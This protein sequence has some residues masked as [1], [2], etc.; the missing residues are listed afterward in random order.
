MCSM[1]NTPEYNTHK[2]SK[3]ECYAKVRSEL[4]RAKTKSV[5][6]H[7]MSRGLDTSTPPPLLPATYT[8][9]LGWFCP[10][11]Q[12]SLAVLISP[13]GNKTTTTIFESN[14]KQSLIRCWPGG[15]TLTRFIPRFPAIGDES[16]LAEA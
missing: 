16:H 8:S 6:S 9:L 15:W 7:L 14:M 2:P 5:V 12:F 4:N 11:L 1:C 3:W 10:C 13:V